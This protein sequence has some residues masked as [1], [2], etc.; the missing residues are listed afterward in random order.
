MITK[1]ITGGQTSADRAALDVAME[2]GIHHGGWIPKGRNTEPGP[3][4][5]RYQ[6]TEMATDEYPKRTEQNVIDSDGTLIISHGE[7]TG[8]LQ[9]GYFYRGSVLSAQ[10]KIALPRRPLN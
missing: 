7:L 4:P 2:E 8:G 6:L 5:E 10:R 3:L 9:I 1:I